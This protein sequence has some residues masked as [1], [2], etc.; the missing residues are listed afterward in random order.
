MPANEDLCAWSNGS[1]NKKVIIKTATETFWE[2]RKLRTW[3]LSLIFLAG[4]VYLV[5]HFREYEYF[6]LL[7]EYQP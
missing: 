2:L 3:F 7:L 6:V 5:T 1:Q 4:L